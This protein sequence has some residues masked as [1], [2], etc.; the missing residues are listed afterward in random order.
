[1]DEN[2]KAYQATSAKT[3]EARIMNS[4]IPKTESEWWASREIARLRKIIDSQARKLEEARKVIEYYKN[5]PLCARCGNP[6][7][8][9]AIEFLATLTEE[10][11]G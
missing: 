1:M 5:Y 9:H 11:E 4:N 2:Y 7:G 10:G 3:H 8:G 6:I